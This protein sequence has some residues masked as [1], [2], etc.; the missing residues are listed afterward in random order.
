MKKSLA[1]FL[2]LVLAAGPALAAQRGTAEYEKLKEYKKKKHE[3]KVA[4]SA[5]GAA[6]KEKGFWQRE[7]ERSGFTGTGAMF[8]RGVSSAFPFEKPNSRKEAK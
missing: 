2:L 4:A 8:T 1:V 3:E 6:P 5:E 7:G